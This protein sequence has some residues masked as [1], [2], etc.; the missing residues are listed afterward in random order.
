MLAFD[1]R[2]YYLLVRKQK[3]SVLE[4]ILDTP[5]MNARLTRQHMEIIR[6]VL[7]QRDRRLGVFAESEAT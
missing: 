1:F 7:R 6:L 2:E 3:T 5:R 4:Q